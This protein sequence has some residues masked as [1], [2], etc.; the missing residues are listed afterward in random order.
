MATTKPRITV[1]LEPDDYAIIR[2]LSD[3]NGESMSS[4][5][6]GLATATRPVLSRVVEAGRA[7]EALS[8][9]RQDAARDLLGDAN[10]VIEPQLQSLQRDVLSLMDDFNDA[11]VIDPDPRP[12]TRGSRPPR[13]TFPL[14]TGRKT[15]GAGS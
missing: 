9:Q 13:E 7:F 14:P 8:A 11:L 1:T 5:L 3:M 6:A 4:I 2:A 12:V 10:A 15:R